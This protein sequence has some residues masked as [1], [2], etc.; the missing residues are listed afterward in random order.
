[1]KKNDLIDYIQHNY[2]T[3]P[4]YP[5]IKYPDYA[6]FRHQGNSRW[7]ALIM[8]VSADK[9]GAGDVKTVTDIINVKVAPELVGSLRLKEGVYPAYHMNKEHWITIILDGKFNSGEL[10][11]LIDD[12]Y[13]LT[14]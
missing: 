4:D 7:F 9:I 11:S 10:K 13:R 1:M 5:W 2:G 6:V 8:S 12:S 3:S 14:Q